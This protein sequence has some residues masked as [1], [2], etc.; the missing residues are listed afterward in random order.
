MS[1]LPT[2]RRLF[3][4]GNA[5]AFVAI[6]PILA[7]VGCSMPISVKYSPLAATE[8]LTTESNP[9][10]AFVVSFVDARENKDKI[11]SMKNLYGM[12]AKK[13]VTTQDFCSL[14]AEATT[15]ALR[16]SGLKA[17]LH[18]ERTVNEDIPADELEKY[19]FVVGGKIESLEV[20]SKP[21]WDTMKI[22]ARVVIH[23]CIRIGSKSEW[24]G[25]IEGTAERR[26]IARVQSDSFT[27]ALDTAMQDCMRNMIRHIKA[28]GVL[29]A[30]QKS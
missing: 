30:L 5:R 27:A 26:E 7:A 8:S 12:E 24:I 25:P 11:G 4:R 14:L 13:L 21:G 20:M 16:K 2:Y 3:L 10:R 23:L 22:T 1:S 29:L 15:D 28:S 6:L 19:D 9:P 17:D 18:S